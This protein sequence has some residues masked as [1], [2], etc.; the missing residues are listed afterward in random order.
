MPTEPS[1]GL[2]VDVAVRITYRRALVLREVANGR[3]E[4]EAAETL[5]LSYTGLRSHVAALLEITQCPDVRELGRWWRSHR[6]AWVAIMAEAAGAEV[7][8]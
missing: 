2:P 5:G 8:R 3:T 7:G 4:Q 1:S 6:P